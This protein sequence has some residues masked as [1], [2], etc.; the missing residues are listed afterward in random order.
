MIHSDLRGRGL[1]WTKN[2][3][4]HW[5]TVPKNYGGWLSVWDRVFGTFQEERLDEEIVYGLVD[6]PRFFNVIQHQLFYFTILS[7][8]TNNESSVKDKFKSFFYGP[9]WFPNLNLPRLGDNNLVEEKPVRT[10]HFSSVG[11]LKHVII[12][13]QLI[14]MICVHDFFSINFNNLTSIQVVKSDLKHSLKAS[15]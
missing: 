9:G 12:L 10:T 6:Q 14:S 3:R 7:S 8:K 15:L 2:R 11:G 5:R 13:L 1:K 4:R